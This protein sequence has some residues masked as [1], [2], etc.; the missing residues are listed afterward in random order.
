MTM[1]WCLDSDGRLKTGC[2][3]LSVL[4]MNMKYRNAP[5]S[6]RDDLFLAA[7]MTD[8]VDVD[9]VAV[10]VVGLVRATKLP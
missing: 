3:G 10:V 4:T 8:Y 2:G 5:E 1:G 9:A 6:C 7:A